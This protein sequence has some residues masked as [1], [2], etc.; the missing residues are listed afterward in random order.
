MRTDLLSKL[1]VVGEAVERYTVSVSDLLQLGRIAD[2]EAVGAWSIAE[3][4]SL[5]Q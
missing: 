5:G 3:H 1:S 4:W 2:T